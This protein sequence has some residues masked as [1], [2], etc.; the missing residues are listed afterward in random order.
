MKESIRAIIE[1]KNK[2]WEHIFDHKIKG[3]SGVFQFVCCD[4]GAEYDMAIATEK[5][6]KIGIAFEYNEESTEKN[7]QKLRK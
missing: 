6:G 4:C 7:R 2:L 5:D 1:N 3:K